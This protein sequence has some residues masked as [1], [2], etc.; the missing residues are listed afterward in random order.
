[1]K[2]SI[3]IPIYNVAAYIERC[4]LSALNQTYQN[5]EIILV[6]DCGNDSSMAISQT[7]IDNHIR[8]EYVKV[9]THAGNRGLSAARNTGIDEATGDYLY[10][11]DSDDEISSDCIA[12][13]VK[14]ALLYRLDFVIANYRTIG[15]ELGYPPLLLEEGCLHTNDQILSH[16][17]KGDWYMMAW[18]KL[19]NRKFVINN[20]L[21]FKEGLIHEDNLWSF[22]LACKASTAY[23]LK[24]VT[25]NYY[26]HKNSI[27]QKPSIRNF[28]SYIEVIHSMV[29]FIKKENT[30]KFNSE[31]YYFIEIVKS[32]FFFKINQSAISD[33]F[34]YSAYKRIRKCNYHS[35]LFYLI[36]YKLEKAKIRLKFHTKLMIHYLL[37]T[38]VGFHYYGKV[39][40]RIYQRN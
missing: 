30:L 34:K 5:I 36:K 32:I 18:N 15:T 16:Y 29:G 2:I 17:L 4:L 27:T 1:M 22:I 35:P 14:P 28:E 37:P 3:I 19:I 10:F 8:G 13:L 9:V 38:S 26:I 39:L 12:I 7:I 21:Y 24:N 33:D 11:L 25:Y 6:D 31:I 23:V 20:Q 40:S